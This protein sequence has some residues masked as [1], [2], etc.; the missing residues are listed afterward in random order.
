[1]PGDIVGVNHR[2]G[3]HEPMKRACNVGFPA[4]ALML[5]L[6]GLETQTHGLEQPGRRAK[7][8]QSSLSSSEW[9]AILSRLRRTRLLVGEDPHNPGHLDT[10]PLVREYFGEQLRDRQ[11]DAWKESNRRCITIIERSR[12]SCRIVSRRWSRFSQLSSAAAMPVC[13]E[14]RCTK[15]TFPRIQRGNAYFVATFL[16]REELC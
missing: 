12:R 8:W 1:M 13:S 5:L 3:R 2:R 4:S 16:E 15:F 11:A 7:D 10:H 9:R 14:R 6:V